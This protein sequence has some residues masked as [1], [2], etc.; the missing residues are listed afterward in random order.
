MTLSETNGIA[1]I[2]T[3]EQLPDILT[4]Q[5]IADYLHISRRRVYELMDL[6]PGAGGIP[7]F[8]IG[9]LAGWRKQILPSG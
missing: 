3:A 7:N 5:H 2:A 8:S 1:P 6:N 4:A 9:I